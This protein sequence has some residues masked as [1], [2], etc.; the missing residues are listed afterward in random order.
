MARGPERVMAWGC[1]TRAV[2]RPMI[3]ARTAV[4]SGT[5]ARAALEA[6]AVRPMT[7]TARPGN[8]EIRFK[9]RISDF[10]FCT[11]ILQAAGA[12]GKVG[13]AASRW[14]RFVVYSRALEKA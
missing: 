14:V 12:D 6:H 7:R 8:Q 13:Q 3:C 4:S 1:T 10:G 11:V 2:G 9:C 5:E